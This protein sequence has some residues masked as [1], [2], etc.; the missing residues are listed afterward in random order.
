MLTENEIQRRLARAAE[1]GPQV[2]SPYPPSFFEHPPLP[3]AV[4]L[5]FIRH[6]HQWHLLMIRRS[7]QDQDRHSGQVAFPGGRCEPGDQNAQQTALREAQEEIGLQPKDARILGR[8]PA[9]RTITNYLVTPFVATLPWPYHLQAQDREVARIF[10]I[11]LEWLANRA[12]RQISQRS[13]QFE[14]WFIPV[15]YFDAYDG[16]V[17]WGASARIT[18]MLLEALGLAEPE[19]P[20]RQ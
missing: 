18:V 20:H 19:E 2:E 5:P 15:I 7:L 6:Q 16:E 14:N 9:F 17:L 1:Q 4:L 3:A 13:L 12:N 10:S 8:L 11:P